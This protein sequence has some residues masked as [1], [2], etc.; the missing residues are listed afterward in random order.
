MGS[1]QVTERAQGSLLPRVHSP[2]VGRSY[3][4]GHLLTLG[5]GLQLQGALTY[6]GGSWP[7]THVGSM[8]LGGGVPALGLQG[9][10]SLQA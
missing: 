8:S 2:P 9:L 6:T 3:L 4:G 7:R 5:G 10:P 1:T